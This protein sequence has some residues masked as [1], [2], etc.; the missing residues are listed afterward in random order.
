[1][2][3]DNKKIVTQVFRAWET[4]DRD[5]LEGILAESFTFTSPNDETLSRQQYWEICWAHRAEIT[6]FELLTIIATDDDAFVRYNG[7]SSDGRVF[8]NVEYFTLNNG[9]VT[10]VNVYFGQTLSAPE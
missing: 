6:G 9:K 8:Q 7:K 4:N 2:D 5:L 1:M 10:S 3:T